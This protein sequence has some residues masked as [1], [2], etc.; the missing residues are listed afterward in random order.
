MG[1]WINSE[2]QGFF[3]ANSPS[4]LPSPR[5][6]GRGEG[7]LPTAFTLVE[8][9]V[10]VGIMGLILTIGVPF[11]YKVWHREPMTQAI[12]GVV[13]VCSNAR[14]RSILQGHEVDLVFHPHDGKLEVE[15]AGGGSAPTAGAS[16]IVSSTSTG[17]GLSAQLSDAY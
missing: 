4:P 11:V 7:G 17:S 15:G 9:M 3:P 13:E 5:G 6:R 12:S 14:A 16:S 10:V 2:R 1:E 8:I